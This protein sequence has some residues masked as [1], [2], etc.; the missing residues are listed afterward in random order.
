VSVSHWDREALDLGP[1]DLFGESS[2]TTSSLES[3]DWYVTRKL[4]VGVTHRYTKQDVT[5]VSDPEFGDLNTDYHSGGVVLRWAF[6][7]R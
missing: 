3:F 5:G 7:P 4:T 2:Q 1:A 6:N